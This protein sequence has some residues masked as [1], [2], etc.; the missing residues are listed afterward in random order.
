M[1][2]AVGV[3]NRC[4]LGGSLCEISP[5]SLNDNLATPAIRAAARGVFTN[6][7]HAKRLDTATGD[8]YRRPTTVQP[9]VVRCALQG[10]LANH[11]R[12]VDAPGILLD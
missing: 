3:A 2:E 6:R 10:S 1:S 7:V 12:L 9:Q 4:V 11:P 5:T 8:Y